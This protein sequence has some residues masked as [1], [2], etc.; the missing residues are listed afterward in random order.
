MS[1]ILKRGTIPPTPHTE[2]RSKRG[3]LALEEI[4]GTYGFSG[5]WARKLHKRSY[6][7]EV[8][9][10]PRAGDFSLAPKPAKD[11]NLQPFHIETARMPYA[12]DPIRGRTPLLFGSNTVVSISK[13]AHN[14]PKDQFFRNGDKHE[15]YFVQE[16]SGKLATEYG[17]IPVR[18][19]LY[20]VVPKGT[21]YRFE[22]VGKASLL[23]IESSYPIRWPAHYLNPDGQ[24]N[25][26]A[27]IVETELEAPRLGPAIDRKGAY[28]LDVKHSGGR[29]TRF[30]LGHHPFDLIGWEGAL[31]PFGFDIK[32]HH[33]IAREIHTAPPAHQTFESGRAPHCGFSVCSF[34]AQMEGWHPRDIPAPY[35]HSNVDSDEVMFFSSA[36]YGARE[37][38][39]AEGALTFHPGAVP[40]S[41]HGKAALHS[42]ATRGKMNARRA[43]MLDTFFEPLAVTETAYRYRDKEYPLSWHRAAQGASRGN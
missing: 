11:G 37:G 17:E 10:P 36:S 5:A 29:I 34:V 15:L 22:L 16:G 3:A 18:H 35:A 40:H 43:V 2:F 6:P 14:S 19:G 39:I 27:P 31:Y 38:I 26:T 1:I 13:P 28:T 30:T 20:L 4:H 23:V 42:L 8:S 12:G 33:A 21:T 32:N 25:M 41:P 24:A 9:A 7:T